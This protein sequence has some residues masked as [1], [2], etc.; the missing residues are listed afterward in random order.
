[1]STTVVA[2][3]TD[4]GSDWISSD[5]IAKLGHSLVSTL[6]NNQADDRKLDVLIRCDKNS[7][8]NYVAEAR[9]QVRD[10][11]I[12]KVWQCLGGF[13][14][15]ATPSEVLKIAKMSFVTRIDL[16]SNG[17]LCMDTARYYTDVDWWTLDDTTI[18]GNA[19]GSTTTYS[20][21]DIVIAI[22]DSGIDTG[23]YDLDG[24]K[25]LKFKDICGDS[26]GQTHDDEPYDD[27]YAGHGTHCASIAAG[28]G[29]ASSSYRGVARYAALVVV[30]MAK[31]NGYYEIDDAIDALEWV[32]QNCYTYGIEIVSCSWGAGG[33][34]YWGEY[35]VQAQWVDYLVE[36]YG[37]VVCVAAGN[38]GGHG[39][40]TICT[41]GTAKYAITVGRATDSGEG[42]WSRYYTSSEGPCDDGRVK[43]DILAPGTNINAAKWGTTD[44][45]QEHSGT[46]MA[47]PFVAGLAALWLDEDYS[48][49]YPVSDIHP[50]PRV[51]KL[52]MASATDVPGDSHP[53]LDN[54]Y[55]AGR[56]DAWYE[57]RFYDI[58]ISS[59]S[60]NAPKVLDYSW[61]EQT[62]SHNN[63]PLWVCDPTSGR[64]WY[65][66]DCYTSLF[67]A[68]A[69]LGD[70]DLVM[71]IQV[72]DRYLDLIAQSYPGNH[73]SIGI[74][75]QYSGTYYVRI[76]VEQYSGDYYDITIMTTPS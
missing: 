58:D 68:I 10:M 39:S 32:A 38:D 52:L 21:D 6:N 59:S 16:N 26:S 35:D 22:L 44:Q 12:T 47:T 54:K 9:T 30:K 67:I 37:L 49:R 75:A 8:P 74:W 2:Q 4:V 48:L 20:K 56:V 41:P 60:S 55:G 43:P 64:D 66:L 40:G 73:R 63:E 14:A 34:Q 69:V 25:V 15:E 46:S 3:S 36:N 19:D 51:K 70:P 76:V 57:Q 65:K 29:D 71:R 27:N 1:M 11:T 5:V 13:R 50:H 23:H 42:G 18:D 24:G 31:Y 72:F 17:T 28:S 61:Y 62:Y 53:G 45:Y 7:E 33:T